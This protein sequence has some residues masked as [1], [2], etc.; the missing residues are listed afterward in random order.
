MLFWIVLLRFCPGFCVV[1]EGGDPLVHESF[2]E[3]SVDLDCFG[4]VLSWGFTMEGGYS[5]V[6]E[7]FWKGV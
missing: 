4:L 3:R 6:Y 5:L 2:L 1:I 7:S